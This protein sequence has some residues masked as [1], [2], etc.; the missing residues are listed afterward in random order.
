M[1]I[2][3]LPIWLTISAE[4]S[5]TAYENDPPQKDKMSA[6]PL[7]AQSAERN[8]MYRTTEVEQSRDD[9]RTVE[10][11]SADQDQLGST[12]QIKVCS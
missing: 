10:R 7:V 6:S 9:Y 8:H 5:S 4:Q 12:P 3:S 11:C 2:L 1:L